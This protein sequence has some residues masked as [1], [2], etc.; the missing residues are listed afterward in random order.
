M[1]NRREQIRMD[2]GQKEDDRRD[3]KKERIVGVFVGLIIGL[4]ILGLL[5][6]PSYFSTTLHPSS[7]TSSSVSSSQSVTTSTQVNG[8]FPKGGKIYVRVL[9]DKTGGPIQNATVIGSPGWTCDGTEISI[10]I[11]FQSPVNSTGFASLS[12][13]YTSWFDIDAE[14]SGQT[15]HFRADMYPNMTT[16][17]TVW[18]P[19]CS[20]TTT[21]R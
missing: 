16:Y 8:C 12:D 10:P 18:L 9:V 4:A 11:L 13:N 15:C 2:L 5:A 14:H 3:K 17:V 7:T 6:A 19:S 20:K 1:R 21:Y